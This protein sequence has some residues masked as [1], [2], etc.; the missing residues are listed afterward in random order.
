MQIEEIDMFNKS[1]ETPFGA[2]H[3]AL[4]AAPARPAVQPVPPVQQRLAVQPA[5]MPAPSAT[6][7][8]IGAG[9]TVV[10]KLVGEGAVNIFGHFEGE[11]QVSSAVIGEGAEL[12]GAI[13]AKD[14]TIAGRVKGTIHATR[15]R[16]QGTAMVEGDIFH[17]SLSIEENAR[18]EG[19]SRREDNLA[20][21]PSAV[22][23]KDQTPPEPKAQPQVGL[24]DGNGLSMDVRQ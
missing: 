7:S 17:R 18:F 24:V 1:K 13:V 9:M 16:L 12:D 22:P 23:A 20:D 14:L 19:M 8:V 15:V 5:A 10:G 6:A 21:K 4:P 2:D 11:L 3:D